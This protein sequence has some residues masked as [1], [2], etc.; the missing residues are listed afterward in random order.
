MTRR[1]ALIDPV[2]V[3]VQL[4]ANLNRVVSPTVCYQL[5]D[6]IRR[7]MD[8][9]HA[10][11]GVIEGDPFLAAKV[12]GLANVGRRPGDPM[13]VSINRAV[14]VL[15]TG[16][17]HHLVLAVMLAGPLISPDTRYPHREDLWRYVF[18][19]A[20]AGD[21]L[22]HRRLSAP[23]ADGESE[24]AQPPLDDEHT[25]RLVQGLLLGLGILILQAGMGRSYSRLLEHPL[26]P[27]QLAQR[28][29]Q[30]LGAT[31]HQVTLWAL[32]AMR[33]PIELGRYAA[34]LMTMETEDACNGL[35][36]DALRARAIEHLAALAVGVQ[37]QAAENWLIAH[38]PALRADADSPADPTVF[39]KDAAAFIRLRVRHLAEVFCLDLGD[40]DSVNELRR[41]AMHDASAQLESLIREQ[42][43]AS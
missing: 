4:Q 21:W 25:S 15:G 38:L 12:V 26:R 13:I 9:F 32:Q 17:V 7:G 31:H 18:A 16:P 40:D 43:R 1:E 5:L 20:G 30:T 11:A 33:C 6:L 29:Y 3:E 39:F 19:L 23:V 41:D 2:W 42:R 27:L 37:Q 24:P 28:E 36:G 35:D 8:N 10:V 22:D 14:A 34:A